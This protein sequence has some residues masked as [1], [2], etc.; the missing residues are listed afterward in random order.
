MA[1]S[2]QLWQGS[3]DLSIIAGEDSQGEKPLTPRRSVHFVEIRPRSELRSDV[4]RARNQEFLG[5]RLNRIY[6]DFQHSTWRIL[7]I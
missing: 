3:Y 2:K 5:V 1:T 6:D 4:L 7:C